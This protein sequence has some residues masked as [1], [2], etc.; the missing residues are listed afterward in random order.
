MSKYAAVHK[1]P[2]GP[3]DAR[4]TAMQIIKDEELEGKMKDKTFLI[5]GCSS[6]IG[7]ETARAIAATGATVYCTA[8]DMEKGKEALA[9]ILEPRRV[10]LLYMD[11][12]ALD[13]VREAA[14][15]FIAKT[16]ERPINVLICNAGV[17]AIPAPGTTTAD[18]FETQFGIN[19]LAHFLLFNLLKP[20]L[21]ASSTRH[22]HSRVIMVSSSG[23][24]LSEVHFGDY[25]FQKGDYSPFGAYGQSKTAMIYMANYIDRHFGPH[26]I[27]ANSL[28]PGSIWT[29][30]QRHLKDEEMQGWKENPDAVANVKSPEQ[31]AAT[32][33]WAAVGKE[34]EGKGGKF[35]E[36]VQITSPAKE[37]ATETDPGYA[38]WAFD[39][40]KEDRLWA[41]SLKMVGLASEQK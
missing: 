26:G 5:T 14:E 39:A 41:D 24:K 16:G 6:G 38:K 23:H 31:G 22:F 15:E 20:R 9:D 40:E 34:W 4:P 18:G 25:N 21:L 29:P 7:V 19:Y 37:G 8:R 1:S 35:L 28:H 17:M 12:T 13:I 11:L 27:H 33:V 36:D 10:E 30:L 2:K 32:T 3:G